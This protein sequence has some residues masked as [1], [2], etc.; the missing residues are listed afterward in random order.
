MYFKNHVSIWTVFAGVAVWFAAGCQPNTPVP[1]P[2]KSVDSTWKKIEHALE[3]DTIG[4]RAIPSYL[5]M[6]RSKSIDE[7]NWMA[8][9]MQAHPDWR[10]N[11]NLKAAASLMRAWHYYE[12][13][14]DSLAL[15]EY[16]NV[17]TTQIDLQLSAIQGKANYYYFNNALDSARALFLKSYQIA[18]AE[19]NHPWILRSANNIGTLYFDL[20]EYSTASDYFTE[21]LQSA[22]MLK[23]EVPMLINNIITCSLVDSEPEEALNLYKK[24]SPIFKPVNDYERTIY[25]LN[26]IHLFWK[27]QQFDTFKYHLD[28]LKIDNLGE[29]VETKRDQQYLFYY[30]YIK[31]ISRFDVLFSKYRAQLID[32]PNEFLIQ[33]GELLEY[34]QSKGMSVFNYKELTQFYNKPYV[35]ANKKLKSN[36][37][38]LLSR[39]RQGTAEGDRWKIEFL[40][41][42]LDIHRSEALNFQNNLKDQI[43]INELY[44]ENNEIKL[45]LELESTEKT[46]YAITA[47]GT[48]LVLLLGGITFVFF[49]KNR[50]NAIQKL[51]LEL[52]NNRNLSELNQSKKQF[53]ERLISTNQVINKKLDK[54]ASKLKQSNFGKDPEIIQIRRELEGITEIK[55]DWSA[56]MN[57]IKAIDGIHYL[58]DYFQCVQQFN[59][60]EQTLLAYFITGHKVKEIATLM[61]LSEQHVRN[62]KTKVLKAFSQEHQKDVSI[63]QLISLRE[64]GPI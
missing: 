19:Q 63:D 36:L 9:R 47:I 28:R 25:E 60:T 49:Q 48:I 2:F 29:I 41:T 12:G 37:S 13:E 39:N 33:W 46:V 42:E 24:Y 34:A 30:A 35:A 44:N 62:T 14:Q 6:L 58:L 61:N 7:L 23:V 4:Y 16:N 59:Q 54:I 40:S 22:Q 45:K 51:Q 64:K 32:N 31:D 27:T 18:K 26:R 52:L 20:S 3:V 43:K 50:K 57:Q 8:S 21:A 38:Y 1:E 5:W 17:R 11:D 53:A 15:L 55:G 56:E 10:I